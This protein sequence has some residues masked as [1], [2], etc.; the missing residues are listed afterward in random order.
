[1]SAI[2]EEWMG[3]LRDLLQDVRNQAQ[4]TSYGTFLGGDPN[5]FSPDPECSTE[6]ERALHKADCEKWTAGQREGL[7]QTR[8]Y[9]GPVTY[10]GRTG[11]GRIQPSGYGL[12]TTSL[13]DET[14]LEVAERLER[15][16]GAAET[17]FEERDAELGLEEQS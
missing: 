11:I 9:E 7:T 1:M 13:E 10:K 17:Y 3:E 5:S 16:I 12:G 4:D 15:I 2:R 6:A 8:C 14:M